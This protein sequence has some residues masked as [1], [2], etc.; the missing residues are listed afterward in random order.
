MFQVQ[1]VFDRLLTAFMLMVSSYFIRFIC[2][3]AFSPSLVMPII[4]VAVSEATHSVVSPLKIM[5][6]APNLR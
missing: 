6:G 4:S 2:S 5:V 3:T 1:K